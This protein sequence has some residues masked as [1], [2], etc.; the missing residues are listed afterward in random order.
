MVARCRLCGGPTEHRNVTTEKWWGND[1]AF[2]ENVPAWVCA[3]CGEPYFDAAT[4]TQ[5]DALRPDA[6]R[7]VEVPVYDFGSAG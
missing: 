2:I 4:C 6:Q 1:L 7:K 5:L 3:I